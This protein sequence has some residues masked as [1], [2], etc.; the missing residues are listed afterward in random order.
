MIQAWE[1]SRDGN[2]CH[3]LTCSLKVLH[4]TSWTCTS[5]FTGTDRTSPIGQVGN[6]CSLPPSRPPASSL[7]ALP[8]LNRIGLRVVGT[9]P[10]VIMKVVIDG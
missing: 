8:A 9:R 6:K 10:R 4:G 5:N 7:S 3:I 2:L 1:E